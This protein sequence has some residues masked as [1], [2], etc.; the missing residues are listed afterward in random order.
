MDGN[1]FYEVVCD[2]STIDPEL[3]IFTAEFDSSGQA[4]TGEIHVGSTDAADTDATIASSGQSA[5]VIAW[6]HYATTSQTGPTSVEL[7][8][9][10]GASATG[11]VINIPSGF[12][13][14]SAGQPSIAYNGLEAVLAYTDVNSSGTVSEVKAIQVSLSARKPRSRFPDRRQPRSPAWPSIL[15]PA[16]S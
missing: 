9:F 10:N 13:S 12:S 8:F 5:Y 6:T 4:L 7:Q 2:Q 15:P 11:S 3:G 14:G 1:G 16:N